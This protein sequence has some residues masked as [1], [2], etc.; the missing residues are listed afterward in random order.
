MAEK[1]WLLFSAAV[2]GAVQAGF[3]YWGG[4]EQTWWAAPLLFSDPACPGGEQQLS[5]GWKDITG[6]S[7][8]QTEEHTVALD[9][10]A[11]QGYSRP[12]QLVRE[13]SDSH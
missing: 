1:S 9:V 11:V 7:Q 6:V 8:V 10:R 13:V 4:A 12:H 2:P 5:L 3:G